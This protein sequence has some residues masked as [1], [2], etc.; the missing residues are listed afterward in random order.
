MS[1]L[2]MSD[3]LWPHQAPLFMGFHRQ[4]YWNGLPFLLLGNLS[5]LGI[6]PTLLVPPALAGRLFTTEPPGKPFAYWVV[7]MYQLRDLC[8]HL[9]MP[10]T[11]VTVSTLAP[12]LVIFL[13]NFFVHIS[14]Y[15]L[16]I[17]PIH[18]TTLAKRRNVS[19]GFSRENSKRGGS[20]ELLN[21]R[22]EN[23]ELYHQ[24]K[25][26][27][28]CQPVALSATPMHSEQ[29]KWASFIHYFILFLAVLGPHRFGLSLVVMSRGYSLAVV[30]WLS[31]WWLF[32]LQST[33]YKA[34]DLQ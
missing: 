19:K 14:K 31:W 10:N 18:D 2:L 4:D 27:Y 23:Q 8:D 29:R 32:L 17:F 15:T 30:V 22:Y 34:G 25:E 9:T 16:G 24:H 1:Q 5:D 12:T 7:K 11:H 28:Q 20:T 6:K 13:G 33:V 26:C 21:V 3:S